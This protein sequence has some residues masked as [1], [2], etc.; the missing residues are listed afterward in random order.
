MTN[1]EFYQSVINA[2]INPDVTAHAEAALTKLDAT[3]AKR[4]EKA[5]EKNEAN[6]TLIDA[7]LP[8]LTTEPQTA[9]DMMV[10]TGENVQK[11]SYLL[12]QAV[13]LGL[14]D[15]MDV[16]VAKKG[17]QKGY[18]INPAPVDGEVVDAEFTEVTDVADVEG[19]PRNF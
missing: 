8:Y 10:Y 15:V 18:F 5:A 7:M 3:N 1:R 19:V 12:R 2:A 9:N 16:K 6:R 4:A 13:K 14:C 17:T 11:T